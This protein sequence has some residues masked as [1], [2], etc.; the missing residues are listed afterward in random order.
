MTQ[1]NGTFKNP[2]SKQNWDTLD[3]NQLTYIDA[4]KTTPTRI[5]DGG[6]SFTE[7]PAVVSDIKVGMS[8][9]G[10][11]TSMIFATAED[12]LIGDFVLVPVTQSIT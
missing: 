6:G 3:L 4:L 5:P 9:F 2:V 8:Y 10:R 1:P 12:L 11:Q 7:V